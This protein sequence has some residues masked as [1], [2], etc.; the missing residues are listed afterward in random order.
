VDTVWVA[1]H[2]L[3]VGPTAAAD[4]TE[5][6]EAYTTLGFLAAQTGRVRLGTMVTG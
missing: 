2:L 4:D 5:M 1:D 3:Q 6:L